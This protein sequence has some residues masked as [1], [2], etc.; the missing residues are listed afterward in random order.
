MY[1]L[2]WEKQM[3]DVLKKLKKESGF[4]I[5]LLSYGGYRTVYHDICIN[6]AGPREFLGLISNAEFVV[7]SSFHG[8]VFSIIYEKP[9]YSFVN[10]SLPDRIVSLLK[11]FNL[12]DRQ[13]TEYKSMSNT[14]D[15]KNVK[16]ILAEEVEK[17]KNYLKTAIEG[18]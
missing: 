2:Y 15:Y 1:A 5:V 6:S 3:N 12:E 7:S 8:S 9:F 10:P 13:I 18:E 11:T 4:D 14:I 17:S 16:R